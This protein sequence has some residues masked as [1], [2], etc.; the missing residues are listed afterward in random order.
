LGFQTATGP[1]ALRHSGFLFIL[2][3]VCLWLEHDPHWLKRSSPRLEK[4]T[5]RLRNS[6]L[7]WV[8]LVHAAAGVYAWSFDYAHPFSEGKVAAAFIKANNL[9]NLLLMG[10]PG[11][12]IMPIAAYLDQRVYCLDN[13]RFEGFHIATDT[14]TIPADQLARDVGL[15]VLTNNVN[16]L[17][18][19]NKALTTDQPGGPTPITSSWYTVESQ[20]VT[21]G[22]P[23]AGSGTMR[24]SSEHLGTEG[25]VSITLTGQFSSGVS[26]EAFCIYL[27]ERK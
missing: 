3:I 5:D 25:I 4:F 14:N 8:L 20:T 13:G 17:L 22:M 7:A 26:G 21:P 18:I 6:F 12:D 19:V 11:T 9:Q 27:I 10:S 16:G 2:Y 24:R 1:G 15:L 23:S